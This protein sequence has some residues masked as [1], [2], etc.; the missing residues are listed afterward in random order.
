MNK[1][2]KLILQIALLVLLHRLCL[3]FAARSGLPIPANV[4]GIIVLFAL[5]CTGIVKERHIA[6]AVDF[7][8]EHL[9]FFF[10]PVAVEL[11]DWGGVFYSYGIALLATIIISSFIP[12][13]VVGFIVQALYEEEKSCSK[14]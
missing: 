12:L 2:V 11:M 9:A 3:W 10:I 4:L 8:F 7:L 6:E 13:W 14:Q 5:L 1:T